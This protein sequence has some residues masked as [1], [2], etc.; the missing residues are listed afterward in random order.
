MD[1]TTKE[2]LAVAR[3]LVGCNN[4]A[5]PTG[6]EIIK[7]ARNRGSALRASYALRAVQVERGVN[8]H[9]RATLPD[10]FLV[11]L[12]EPAVAPVPPFDDVTGIPTAALTLLK[13]AIVVAGAAAEREWKD[14]RTVRAAEAEVWQRDTA[15]LASQVQTLAEQLDEATR[16]HRE[17]VAMH[18][19]AISALREEAGVLRKEVEFVRREAELA[20]GTVTEFKQALAA[21]REALR[22]ETERCR[23]AET[24]VASLEASLA[25]QAAATTSRARIVVARKRSLG[26]RK[27]PSS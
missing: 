8:A 21:A 4:K 14:L 3:G 2:L 22:V 16:A 25:A 20:S 13:D 7:A 11:E 17:T 15:E 27:A 26:A 9:L 23:V 24:R 1:I 6:R 10:D 5:F 19:A 18:A 12:V